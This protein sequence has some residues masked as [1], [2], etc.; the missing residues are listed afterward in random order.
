MTNFTAPASKPSTLS[1]S[2]GEFLHKLAASLPIVILARAILAA[3]TPSAGL[4]GS[5]RPAISR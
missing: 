3:W 4:R 5:L 1:P 2:R